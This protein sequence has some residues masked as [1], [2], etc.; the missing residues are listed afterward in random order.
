VIETQPRKSKKLCGLQSGT[1]NT[2]SI[3]KI[4]KRPQPKNDEPEIDVDADDESGVIKKMRDEEEEKDQVMELKDQDSGNVVH[5]KRR[6]KN[7]ES[8]DAMTQTERSDY[9]LIKQRA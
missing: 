8:K 3:K 4:N 9:M 2:S 1:T 5:K 7:V 6:R